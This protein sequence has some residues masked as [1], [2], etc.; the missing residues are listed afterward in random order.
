MSGGPPFVS[1]VVPTR[2]RRDTLPDALLSL[3]AQ[4]YPAERY[5]VV[6]VANGAAEGLRVPERVRLL[7]LEEPNANRARNAGVDAARGDPI[8]FVDDDVVAPPG[9]LSA[10]VAAATRHAA[11]GC[12]GGPVRPRFDSPP[13]RTCAHHELAGTELDE[14]P[15]EREVDEVWGGNMAVT[16][17]AL[18]RTGPL[19]ERLRE[20]H[21]VEWE[22]RLLAA[23]GRIVYA[24]DAWLWH[25]RGPDDLRLDRIVRRSFALGYTVVALGQR[26]DAAALAREA[27]RCT[28]HAARARCTRGLTDAARALGS[29]CAIAA[30]RRRR[31]WATSLREPGGH[32]RSSER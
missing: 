11:A 2:G 7:K 29:L 5:E 9:W 15:H 22:E 18:E 1:V 25:R 10:L 19:L 23:G 20:V 32:A 16:R 31:P 8:C 14:G 21:E 30:G 28:G 3:L 6:V 12:V 4:D 24:P 13:P 17:A 26:R 27:R